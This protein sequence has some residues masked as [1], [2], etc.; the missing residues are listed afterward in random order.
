SVIFFC[1]S[2]GSDLSFLWFRG[3]SEITASDRVQIIPTTGGSYL[4]I[5]SVTRYDQGTYRCRGSSFESSSYDSASLVV[6]Y[7]P[8]ETQL[9]VLPSQGY[10]EGS[11]V[12]L[13]CSAVSNPPAEF[14]WFQYPGSTSP[15]TYTG[16]VLTFSKIQ[17]SDD[18]SYTC[19][20]FNSKTQRRHTSQHRIISVKKKP[21][22]TASVTIGASCGCIGLLIVG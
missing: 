13:R 21:G 15:L 3:S 1:S 16:P 10:N 9:E 5:V 11:T 17:M 2:T 8:E 4:N 7:G 22:S 20:A 12:T 19:Q 6:N 18:G 14:S